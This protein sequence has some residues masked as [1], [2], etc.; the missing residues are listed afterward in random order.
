MFVKHKPKSVFDESLPVEKQVA[1]VENS[2]IAARIY[3]ADIDLRAVMTA[4]I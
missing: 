3:F 1:D 2:G 4:I